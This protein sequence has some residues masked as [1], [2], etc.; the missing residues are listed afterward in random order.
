MP[1]HDRIRFGV[2]PKSWLVKA[3]AAIMLLSMVFRII[4]CWQLWD[5]RMFLRTQIILPL[6]CNALYVLCLLLFGRR[7]FW[8]TSIPALF[9][10]VFFII[11]AFT[12]ESM[13]H[14]VLCVMLYL[15][16]A[17]LYTG[18]A[19]G[20]IR[21]KWLL[22]PLFGLPLLYHLAM[23]DRLAL[24]AH[25]FTF[26]TGMQELSVLCIMLSLLLTAFALKKQVPPPPQELP[27]MKPPKVLRP[28]HNPAAPPTEE[29][30]HPDEPLPS[31][32][33]MPASEHPMEIDH[34]HEI[35]P[36]TEERK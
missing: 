34:E 11:K 10:V 9:G 19:F 12:F 25:T 7:A 17:V 24:T 14:T 28:E 23:E 18:T 36:P 31:P 33:A 20:A 6:A 1:E 21:T 30:P 3:A 22:V 35:Q 13:L 27:R 8:T 5:D 16:V 29:L 32:D 15:L 2:D 26:K 4:G